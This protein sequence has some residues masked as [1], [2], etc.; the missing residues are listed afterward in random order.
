MASYQI[1]HR[2]SP[3]I[4]TL[5]SNCMRF[6]LYIIIWVIWLLVGETAKAQSGPHA[7]TTQAPRG[8]YNFVVI[9]GSGLS[10][11]STHLGVPPALEQSHISRFG[12][13]ATIRLMW[14]PDHRLRMG[15]ETGWTTMY[16]YKGHIASDPAHVYVSLTPVLLV[17]SMPMAWLSGTDRSIARRVSATVGT[18]VYFNHSRLDYAGTVISNTRSLGWMAAGSYAQP[19]GRR[20]RVAGELKWYDAVAAENAAFAAE[21][22]LIWRAFSW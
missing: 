1:I 9:V 22:Q 3:F 18:G 20:F 16:S 8:P 7:D 12:V 2:L 19:I 21:I 4:T 14:F 11:Y 13:P 10:Y 17:F 15:I 5:N 6:R